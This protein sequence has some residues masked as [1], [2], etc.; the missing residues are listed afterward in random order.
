M[1]SSTNVKGFPIV[2]AD[3][4][5]T[6]VGYIDRSELRY[7]LGMPSL[8]FPQEK[9]FSSSAIER[10]RKTRGRF[11]HTPCLFT[12][13]GYDHDD[14][15][16]LEEDASERFFAPTTEGELQFWPWVNQVLTSSLGFF[17]D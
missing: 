4:S 9:S 16:G 2:S 3:G 7:V 10:A 13:Q 6:L 17:S 11:S 14:S 15:D 12:P 8:C 5:L 1:L